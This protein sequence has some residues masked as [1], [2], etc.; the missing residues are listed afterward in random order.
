MGTG[1]IVQPAFV[2]TCVAVAASAQANATRTISVSGNAEIWG[3]RYGSQMTQERCSGERRPR[4]DCRY[5]LVPGQI[6]VTAT[7]NVTFELGSAR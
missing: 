1:R 7:I 2:F 3:P 5:A 4:G 6:S